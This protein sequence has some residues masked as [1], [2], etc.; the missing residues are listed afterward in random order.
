MLLIAFSLLVYGIANGITADFD[1][2]IIDA[3]R[4]VASAPMDSVMKAITGIG[5]TRQVVIILAAVVVYLLSKKQYQFALFI[6]LVNA[7]SPLVNTWLK[8][9]FERPRPEVNPYRIYDSYSFPSGHATAVIVMFMTLCYL[10]YHLSRKHMKAMVIFSTTVVLLVGISRVYLGVHYPT[11]VLGGY[12]AGSLWVILSIFLFEQY[13]IVT[14]KNKK[15][16]QS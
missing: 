11:D 15:L 12:I 14:N 10:V 16:N 4:S 6:V 8:N 1:Q 9:W 5:S 13:S 7:I 3:V 2:A